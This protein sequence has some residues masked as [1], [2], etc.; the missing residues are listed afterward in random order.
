VPQ[1]LGMVTESVV[2]EVGDEGAGEVRAVGTSGNPRLFCG[3][4]PHLT[5]AAIRSK[6]ASGKT[7]I[8]IEF[9]RGPLPAFGQ[10][11]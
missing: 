3:T 9:I 5:L 4:Q 6:A 1:D 7:A 8:A 2:V 11:L 10:S